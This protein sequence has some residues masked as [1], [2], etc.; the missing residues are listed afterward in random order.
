MQPD[1]PGPVRLLQH[2]PRKILM[3]IECLWKTTSFY[4]CYSDILAVNAVNPEAMAQCRMAS[5]LR[6]FAWKLG[7]V[8]G[9]N[10]S[11]VSPQEDVNM[12][13]VR[14]IKH[15]SLLPGTPWWG[16]IGSSSVLDRQ[17]RQSCIVAFNHHRVPCQMVSANLS[18]S[19]LDCWYLV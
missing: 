19:D 10:V 2:I 7:D 3:T 8:G 17:P 14:L 18:I 1:K 12:P 16:G 4:H 13:L 5:R 11:R 15:M 6:W 9:T